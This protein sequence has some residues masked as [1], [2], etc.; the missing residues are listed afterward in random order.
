LANQKANGDHVNDDALML[1][2]NEASEGRR[3]GRESE[4]GRAGK[5]RWREGGRRKACSNKG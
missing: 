1:D 4:R 2:D 3:G 5:E